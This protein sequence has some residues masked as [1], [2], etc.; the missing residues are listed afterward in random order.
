MI[1]CSA[2]F[3]TE[4]TE[5]WFGLIPDRI[6]WGPCG[7]GSSRPGDEWGYTAESLI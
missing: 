1:N 6:A 4:K 7:D 2:F 3:L 5:A